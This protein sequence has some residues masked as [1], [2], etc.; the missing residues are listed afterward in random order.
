[1]KR[2]FTTMI[3]LTI[4]L[5]SALLLILPACADDWIP[6]DPFY[7]ISE[8]GSRIF[9]V[10]PDDAHPEEHPHAT[11]LYYNTNPPEL[12]YLVDVPDNLALWEQDFFFTGDLDYFA[13]VPV[14]NLR[15]GRFGIDEP[16]AIVFYAHGNVQKVYGIS[17]LV[18]DQDLL[19]L[20]ASTTQWLNADM[21]RGRFVSITGDHQLNIETIEG[22]TYVF[23]L[24]T[25]EIIE[26]SGAMDD[27]EVDENIENGDI[28]ESSLP[29]DPLVLLAGA[30]IIVLVLVGIAMF[31]IRRRRS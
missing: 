13:W 1:M 31:F 29:L 4:A 12:I 16:I 10:T 17:D 6:P 5:F 8:D 19:I 22:V 25:G 24:L 26:R 30:V 7:V 14:V 18:A 28:S 11:G 23:D 20:T 9:F 27:M 21:E 15:G 2:F 3:I